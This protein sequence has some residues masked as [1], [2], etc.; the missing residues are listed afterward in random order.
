MP[1]DKIPPIL[2]LMLDEADR[3]RSPEERD[4][5]RRFLLGHGT[6]KDIMTARRED[7]PKRRDR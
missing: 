5:T 3:P 1:T 4:A 7:D 2:R 6:I